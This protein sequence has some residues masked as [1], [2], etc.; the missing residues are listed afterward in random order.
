MLVRLLVLSLVVALTESFAQDANVVSDADLGYTITPPTVPPGATGK[1]FAFF[2]PATEGF[3]SNV[4][5]VVQDYGGTLADY[6]TLS[7]KQLNDVNATVLID[8]MKGDVLTYEYTQTMQGK[9]LH[10]YTRAFKH[11]DKLVYAACATCLE[12]NSAQQMPILKA[13]VDSFHPLRAASKP[14][15]AATPVP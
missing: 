15:T 4:V 6:D 2:L 7:K 5:M 14:A 10:F 12:K 8:A 3:A 1:V 13:S 11:G 9:Q